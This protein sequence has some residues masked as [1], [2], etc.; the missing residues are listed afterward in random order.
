[1][2]GKWLKQV[3]ILLKMSDVLKSVL[4]IL[5]FDSVFHAKW[6]F[7]MFS[8]A[9]NHILRAACVLSESR[10]HTCNQNVHKLLQ[11]FECLQYSV[12]VRSI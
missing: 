3:Q 9:V 7:C 2:D 12:Y 8:N 11:R 10:H 6:I 1:M 4:W 5:K